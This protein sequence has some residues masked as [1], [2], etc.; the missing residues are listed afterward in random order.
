MS[1]GPEGQT[2]VTKVFTGHSV[3][4]TGL[5]PDTG[6][7]ITLLDSSDFQLSGE[8]LITGHTLPSV[9]IT[10]MKTELSDSTAVVTWEFEGN[11]PASWTVTTTGTEGYTDTQTVLEP[12]VTL[13]NL[14]AGER[15]S[16]IVTCDNM[17]SGAKGEF[18]PDALKITALTAEANGSGGVDVAWRCEADDDDVQWLVVY[19][20]Q[21][22][23]DMSMVAQAENQTATLT[24]LIPGCTYSIEI[25]EANGEKV[26]GETTTEFTVPAAESFD[27]YG[28]TKGY[29]VMYLRPDLDDW[30]VNNLQYYRTT[31]KTSEKI[32]FACE[33]VSGLEDS[34]DT[35]TILLVVRDA[36][37]NVVDHYTGEEVWNNMWTRDKYV[38]ELLRTPEEPGEYTLEIYFNGQRVKTDK[39]VGFTVTE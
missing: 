37:G 29:I 14:V 28:F 30:T 7:V 11:A 5:E 9:T 17:I 36:N 18:M 31:Y 15:Y 35:V 26:G 1:Y 20:L 34:D 32:A 22:G 12:S 21:G 33:S 10:K 27:D 3:T 25:Q 13:E 8:T 23:D 24:G 38:G 2:P 39:E 4:L 16:V 6:Y 19:T